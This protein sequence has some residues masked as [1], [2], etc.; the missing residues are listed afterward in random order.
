MKF[1][2]LMGS[3]GHGWLKVINGTAMQLVGAYVW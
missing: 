1:D 2:Y 3:W